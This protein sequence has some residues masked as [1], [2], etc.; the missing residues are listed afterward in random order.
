MNNDFEGMGEFL[1]ESITFKIN[2]TV[3]A[4]LKDVLKKLNLNSKVFSKV[5]IGNLETST[6]F[7][8]DGNL[9]TTQYLNYT[10]QSKLSYSN[11]Y[12]RSVLTYKWFNNKIIE[13]N[14]IFDTTSINN[15]IANYQNLTQ[16]N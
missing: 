4:G 12:I 16:K 1:S 9:L 10:Y 14:C 11:F 7:Y 6:F 15:E 2:S 8:K 5:S 3:Y 13:V